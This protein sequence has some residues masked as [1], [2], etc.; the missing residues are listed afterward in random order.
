MG[1]SWF[2]VDRKGLSNLMAGRPKGSLVMEL[3]QNAWDT[4][5]RNVKVELK[6]FGK[7]KWGLAVEDDD[8]E[9]FYDLCHAYTLYADCRKRGDPTKRGRFNVGEKLMLSLCESASVE[10]TIG[11]VGF[12]S[13]GRHEYKGMCRA[14]G[15]LVECVMPLKKAEA[16]EILERLRMLIPPKGVVTTINGE[17]LR[18]RECEFEFN[19]K[20]PTVKA[21]DDGIMRKVI[22]ECVVEV[23]PV[24]EEKGGGWLFEM[25]IPVVRTRDYWSYNIQQKVPLTQDRENVTGSYLKTVRVEVLNH[26]YDRLTAEAVEGVWV[27]EAGADERCCRKATERILDLRFGKKRVIFDPSDLEANKIAINQGYT[28]VPGRS[29]SKG[30]WENAKGAGALLPAGKVTPSGTLFGDNGDGEIIPK[31][32]WTEGQRKIVTYAMMLHEEL[33]GADYVLHVQLVKDDNGPLATYGKKG[34]LNGGPEL[35]LN[36]GKLRGPSWRDGVVGVDVDQVLLH[37]FGHH[38][39]SDHFTDEYISAVALLGARLKVMALRKPEVFDGKE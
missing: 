15:T 28:V 29:L 38:W 20:L 23:Y 9:G 16:K 33:V 19:A 39:K 32:E 8:K 22:R 4:E 12:D 18:E 10:T 17:V 13:E 35:S 26:G 30:E 27:R 1:D 24:E 36:Y 37:E 14:A 11:R 2:D 3:V 34:L 5:A 21:G 7:G 6:E 25:G 31:E